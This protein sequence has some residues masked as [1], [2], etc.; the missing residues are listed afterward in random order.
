METMSRAS[1]RETA[2]RRSGSV[3]HSVR[4]WG[5]RRYRRRAA[6][7]VTRSGDPPVSATQRVTWSRLAASAASMDRV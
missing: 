3:V 4:K 5:T 1:A 6:V 7:W 2:A